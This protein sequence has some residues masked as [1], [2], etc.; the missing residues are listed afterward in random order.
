MTCRQCGTEIAA[1]A[2]ICYRCGCATVAPRVTPPAVS[3][4]FGRPKRGW[5]ATVIVLV[6]VVVAVAAVALWLV[7]G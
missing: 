3:P 7:L 5:S 4:I 6:L 1:N 2:L